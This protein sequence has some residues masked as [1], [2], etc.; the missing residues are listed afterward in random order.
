MR[1]IRF[2]FVVM[3]SFFGGDTLSA[4]QLAPAEKAIREAWT[5]TMTRTPHPKAEGCFTGT[6]PRIEWQEVPC[7]AAPD[8]LYPP[9]TYPPFVWPPPQVVGGTNGDFS[10]QVTGNLSSAVGSFDQVNNVTSETDNLVPNIYSLQLNTGDMTG[11]P[12]CSGGVLATC[13]S[14]QQFVYSTTLN[15]AFMQYWLVNYGS[16]SRACPT[17]WTTVVPNC[18]ITSAGIP[19][20]AQP[21]SN[22]ANLSVT[23]TAVS[24]GNDTVTLSTGANTYAK[25]GND[26]VIGLANTWTTAE[27]NVVGDGN[28]SQ[29]NFNAGSNIIVRTSVSNGT[30]NVP[31]VL[32]LSFTEEKNNFTL[33][34]PACPYGGAA[35]AIVFDESTDPGATSKCASGTSIGD[36]HLTNVN[37]LL[38]DFQASGDF[39]L[40]QTDVDFVVQTRQVSGAPTWPNASVNKAVA[41]KM[42]TTR[43]AVCLA[44]N[45]LVIDGRPRPLASGA[46]LSL[47]GVFITRSGNTYLFTRPSGESVQTELNGAIDEEFGNNGW[48]NANVSLGRIP[49]AWVHGL[50]GNVNGNTGPDDLA[51]RARTVLAQPVSFNDLY[52]RYGDSWRVPDAES[53]PAQLCGGRRADRGNPRKPFFANDLK[54]ADYRRARD[55]CVAAQVREGALLDACTL[56][57]AVLGDKAA[58]EAFARANPPRAV[59]QLGPPSKK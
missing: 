3:F 35:P 2:L 10:A 41:M 37:G 25:S 50:L 15:L 46:S 19:V 13:R 7:T 43:V 28:S 51:S 27:Y 55:I 40:A 20:P 47:P 30:V 44:P 12:A 4:Q 5:R 54:Q 11:S 22:L 39:L 23:G 6:Y 36:T 16:P 31:T 38:Y 21:L 49:M 29:A 59:L 57:V 42:G 8:R 48:I 58:A 17:G 53:L 34:P 26:N 56:D 24:G 14:F 1:T 45:R 52:R 33:V 18:V 32:T 9:A